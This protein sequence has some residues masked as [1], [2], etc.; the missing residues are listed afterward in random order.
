MRMTAVR[1]SATFA[2]LLAAF[3]AAAAD[4]DRYA[5]DLRGAWTS[6]PG[7]GRIQGTNDRLSFGERLGSGAAV[8]MRIAG[9][10]TIELAASNARK[11]AMLRGAWAAVRPIVRLF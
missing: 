11:P 9:G 7:A 10:S 4:S 6:L 8:S 2:L 5:V 3:H 1:I